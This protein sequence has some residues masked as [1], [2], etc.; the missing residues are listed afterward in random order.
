[1]LTNVL[2]RV[3]HHGRLCLILGLLAGLA[4]PDLAALLRP[5]LPHMVS[6]LL[7]LT[8]FR[9]GPR[10][11]L[12]VDLRG[13]LGRVLIL[14][15]V[16]PLGLVLLLLALDVGF[17]PLAVA[18]IL[19]LSASSVTGAPN[20]AQMLGADPAVGLRLLVLGT[21]ILPLTTLPVFWL[22]PQ[23]GDVSAVLWASGRLTA[24]VM[25]AVALGFALRLLSVPDLDS[26][27]RSAVDGLTS[28]ML[29]VIVVALMWAIVPTFSESPW[30][31]LSWLAAAFGVNFGLQMACFAILSR[32]GKP[33]EAVPVSIV[34]GNRNIAL[35]LVALPASTTDQLLV[36]I[37]CYQIPMYLTPI[38][39]RKVYGR[40]PV[41]S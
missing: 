22:L 13:A 19:V 27:G 20:F 21:A 33:G 38:L 26:R 39:L 10:E 17:T 4:L 18:A 3:A 15:G 1:M 37:G 36:F 31:L 11:A 9:I 8:A 24:V 28:I 6:I 2:G 35:F 25:G 14:Q 16:L 7:F 5:W 30:L 32:Q 41:T 23:L 40:S 29:G 34:A 12:G